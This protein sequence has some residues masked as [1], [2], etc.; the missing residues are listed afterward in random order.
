MMFHGCWG[1]NIGG[2]QSM[3]DRSEVMEK[4]N[5]SVKSVLLARYKLSKETIDEW[6]SEGREGWL[7][8]AEMKKAGIV[9]STIGLKDEAIDT[10]QIDLAVAALAKAN[11]KN[12]AGRTVTH[13]E[14]IEGSEGIEGI[15]GSAEGSGGAGE[16]VFAHGSG[17]EQAG[18]AENKEAVMIETVDI[19]AIEQAAKD[20]LMAEITPKIAA[21]EAKSATD[22]AMI[23]T[24]T[25]ERDAMKKS[26][27]D[28]SA[29][30]RKLQGERDALK[31]ELEKV[32]T[33]SV[34]KVGELEGRL[35]KLLGGSVSFS[36]GPVTWADAMKTCGGN[37]ATAA[38][39]FPE[40]R[41]EY[42][43]NNKVKG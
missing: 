16:S 22:D 18:A 43:R 37:Y 24:L 9:Q 31:A 20:A 4:M 42:E 17:D 32:R 27:D 6:F 39:Q 5:N 40:L 34:A 29:N 12:Q 11:D 13:G 21:L 30:A 23:A 10:K 1:I 14:G 19:A 33:E 35:S 8:V 36:P 15:E 7:D 38:K 28:A 2:S 3:A 41:K 25:A 26:A